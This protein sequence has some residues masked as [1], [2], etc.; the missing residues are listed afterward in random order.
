M[1]GMVTIACTV[2]LL[3][4]IFVIYGWGAALLALFLTL[5]VFIATAQSFMEEEV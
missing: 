2:F 3:G 1:L 5:L 4:L